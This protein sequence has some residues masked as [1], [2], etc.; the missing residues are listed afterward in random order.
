MFSVEY[1]SL[2]D[3]NKFFKKSRPKQT[4][5]ELNPDMRL[6]IESSAATTGGSV[7][8]WKPWAPGKM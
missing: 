7:G 3:Q 1:S 8:A 6:S 5:K 2:V 4:L